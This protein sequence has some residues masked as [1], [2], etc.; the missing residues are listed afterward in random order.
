MKKALIIAGAATLLALVAAGSFWG[1][2]TYQSARANQARAD[3]LR[4]RGLTEGELFPGGDLPQAGGLSGG[5][6]GFPGGGIAGAIKTIN[7]DTIAVST[8][9]EVATVYLSAETRV[10]KTTLLSPSEL[11]VGMRVMINGETD[12]QGAIHASRI[13]ILDENAPLPAFPT[14]EP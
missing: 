1:G 4:S 5:R 10:E 14:T 9:Q 7:G 2:M 3:F 11:T 6:T 13:M 8:A 12:S